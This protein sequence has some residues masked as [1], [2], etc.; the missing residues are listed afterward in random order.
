MYDYAMIAELAKSR[1][2]DLIQEA[3]ETR[4]ALRVPAS[5]KLLQLIK[6]LTLVLFHL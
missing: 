5:N 4:R 6:T 2:A 3:M 1:H